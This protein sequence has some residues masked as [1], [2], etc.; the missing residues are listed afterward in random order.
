MVDNLSKNCFIEISSNK[1]VRFEILRIQKKVSNRISNFITQ[2]KIVSTKLWIFRRKFVLKVWF[3]QV[4][5]TVD[6]GNNNL[7]NQYNKQQNYAPQQFPAENI[8]DAQAFAGGTTLRRSSRVLSPQD[9]PEAAGQSL[10]DR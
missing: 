5:A 1:F 3:L 7:M 4:N 2:E 6:Y 10:N 9:K 8:N